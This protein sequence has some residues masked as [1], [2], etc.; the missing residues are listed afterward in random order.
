[1]RCPKCGVENVE[2]ATTGASCGAAME[3]PAAQEAAPVAR[4]TGR[5]LSRFALIALIGGAAAPWFQVLRDS[6]GGRFVPA[7]PSMSYIFLTVFDALGLLLPVLAVALGLVALAQV[8][9]RSKVLRGAGL[10]LGGLVMGAA[11]LLCSVFPDLI[12]S[13]AR[14]FVEAMG[15]STGTYQP[16]TTIIVVAAAIVIELVLGFAGREKL[17]AAAEPAPA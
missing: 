2:G 12:P 17:A 10:A 11:G 6:A 8:A 9:T 14:D 4:K 13:G 15:G 7:D 16:V 1:M 3:E 5:R